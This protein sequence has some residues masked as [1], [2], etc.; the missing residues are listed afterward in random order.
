MAITIIAIIITISS[1]HLPAQKYQQ[2]HYNKV[3]ICSKS[4]IKTPGQRYDNG[5]MATA[6]LIIS[7]AAFTTLPK[8]FLKKIYFQ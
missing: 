2:K 6:I 5:L 1:R 8:L 4:T 7:K 3:W